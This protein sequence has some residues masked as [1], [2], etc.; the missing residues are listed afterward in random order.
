MIPRPLSDRVVVRKLPRPDR[1]ILLP[2]DSLLV[3]P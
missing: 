1:D 2:K 3:L